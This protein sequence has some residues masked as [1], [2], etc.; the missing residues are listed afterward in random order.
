MSA[1]A[2]ISEPWNAT[3]AAVSSAWLSASTRSWLSRYLDLGKLPEEIV[4]A[5]GAPHV[6][7]ISHGAAL[8]PLLPSGE[9]RDRILTEARALG[10]QQRELA[11]MGA[12]MIV[13]AAVL[14]RLTDAAHKPVQSRHAGRAREFV[15]R[16]AGGTIVAR[17]QRTA[18]GGG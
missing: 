16:D 10:A 2:I 12:S 17:A 9:Q 5:L 7:G 8:A 1:L 14:R 3:M 11:G 15:I 6:L 18:R 13:A 4:T